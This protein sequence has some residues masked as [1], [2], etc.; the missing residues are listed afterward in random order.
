MAF[1]WSRYVFW[2]A[3]LISLGQARKHLWV[4]R[5]AASA[6]TS[7]T[8]TPAAI[9]RPIPISISPS[10]AW[11]IRPDIIYR[12]DAQAISLTQLLR[13]GLDGWSS[14]TLGVGT[15]SRM[16]MCS[17]QPPAHGLGLY[18]L[19]DVFQAMITALWRVAEYSTLRSLPHR[20]K[21]IT[22]GFLSSRV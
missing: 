21:T 20:A 10:Y 5:A 7:A 16:F 13:E 19:R 22:S 2:L 18:R 8:S 15:P 1:A 14:F 9:A 4:Q 3:G 17:F 6:A 12:T 11:Y